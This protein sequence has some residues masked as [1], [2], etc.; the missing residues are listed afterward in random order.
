MGV[1]IKPLINGYA[2]GWGDISININGIT[3]TDAT[4]IKYEEEQEKVNVYGAGRRPV[5]RGKGR[6]KPMAS[7][8]LSVETV[9]AITRT[10][11]NKMLTN[12]APFPIVV[13]YQPESGPIVKDVICNCE[14]KKNSRDWKEGD[15]TK[16]V[17]LD[18]LISHIEWDK[19]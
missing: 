9:M 1:E 11:P 16:E 10:A 19:Q 18:L 6:V 7:V 15:M 14:F 2:Y 5:R 3:Y 8:T 17:V 13:M 12:I 4:A